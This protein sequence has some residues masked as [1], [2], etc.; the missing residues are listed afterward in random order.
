M[1]TPIQTSLLITGIGMGLVFAAIILLWGMME[2]VV[3]ATADKPKKHNEDIR[4]TEENT[5]ILQPTLQSD[6]FTRKKAAVAAVA[7]A[8]AVEKT[9][10]VS[11]PEQ[12]SQGSIS[13]W[14]AVMRA[15]NL[16]QISNFQKRN[17][18]GSKR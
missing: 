1:N 7:F 10:R 6:Q 8:I 4:E 18:R 13:T 9:V 17:P 11:Q 5:E 12:P 14:Q 16:N 15:G 3:K 2:L